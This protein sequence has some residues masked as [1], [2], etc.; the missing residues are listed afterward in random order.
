MMALG[1]TLLKGL[2]PCFADP[3]SHLK[4]PQNGQALDTQVGL[5]KS[6]RQG[7]DGMA[8]FV[9]GKGVVD[10]LLSF[11]RAFGVPIYC[12]SFVLAA[13]LVGVGIA[14][15]EAGKRL[16][17][18]WDPDEG[19]TI[20]SSSSRGKTKYL[21][22]I[23]YNS[24]DSATLATQ[25]KGYATLVWYMANKRRISFASSPSKW[26][27]EATLKWIKTSDGHALIERFRTIG[28]S[29]HTIYPK[30]YGSLESYFPT[31]TIH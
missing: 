14:P 6:P 1:R 20:I 18:V 19:W 10:S 25:Q 24:T 12:I 29:H 16:T 22:K 2:A 21:R 28:D 11:I 31:E 30:I 27:K 15:A 17:S 7:F 4:L 5:T 9:A 23:D 8:A 3:L 13:G 26:S